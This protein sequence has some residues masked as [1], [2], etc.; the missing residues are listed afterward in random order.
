[1]PS[2]VASSHVRSLDSAKVTGT[3]LLPCVCLCECV[4]RGAPITTQAAADTTHGK[5]VTVY[6]FKHKFGYPKNL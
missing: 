1:M 4:E 2:G 6:A 5:S 3:A